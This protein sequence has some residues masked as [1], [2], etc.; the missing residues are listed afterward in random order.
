M[1]PSILRENSRTG[2]ALYDANLYAHGVIFY[3]CYTP[4]SK[5]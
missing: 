2:Q 5:I 4:I 1:Q 3:S